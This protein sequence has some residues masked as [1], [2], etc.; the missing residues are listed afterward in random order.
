MMI[1]NQEEGK[2]KSSL[3]FQRTQGML[4]K[5]SH[6]HTCL[7]FEGLVMGCP[8]H[9]LQAPLQPPYPVLSREKWP[10]VIDLSILRTVGSLPGQAKR[11]NDLRERE[12][13]HAEPNKRHLGEDKF[14][15]VS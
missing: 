10:S 13:S 4:E 15:K 1:P 11:P 14:M 2:F 5:D 12:E 6:C 8:R 7:T 9:D 3:L